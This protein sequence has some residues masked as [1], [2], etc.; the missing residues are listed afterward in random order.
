M[1]AAYIYYLNTEENRYLAELR[2]ALLSELMTG[3]LGEV[4]QEMIGEERI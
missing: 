2:D 1:E 3:Q 4:I